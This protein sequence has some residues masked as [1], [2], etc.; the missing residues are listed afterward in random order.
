MIAVTEK[1]DIILYVPRSN[2]VTA[3]LFGL[4][5]LLIGFTT[6]FLAGWNL[7]A[8]LFSLLFITGGI[9]FGPVHAWKL[10][11]QPVFIVNA[12]GI[13]SQYPTLSIAIKWDEIDAIYRLSRR[14]R[15]AF[16]VD[17]SPAGLVA[18]FARQGKPIPRGMDIT[19]PQEA[20]LILS[21]NL[22]IPVDELLAQIRERFAAQLER[23]HI[24]IDYPV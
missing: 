17:M 10:L 5:C 2:L 12:E 18:F 14:N 13:H 22:P 4:M 16:G 8:L 23:Y 1:Q 7:P 9:W 6:P 20:L 3:V 21:T 19:R 15:S 24:D 11:H